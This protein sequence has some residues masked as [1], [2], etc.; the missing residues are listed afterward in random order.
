[1]SGPEGESD[2]MINPYDSIARVPAPPILFD[3]P[4]DEFRG[5]NQSLESSVVARGEILYMP[6]K[7]GEALFLVKQGSVHLLWVTP[8]GR[9]L[10]VGTVRPMICFG[11]MPHLGW[12]MND[13][14]AAAA[15]ESLVC[16]MG[17]ADVER[18]ILSK[19]QIGLRMMSIRNLKDQIQP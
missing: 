17:R 18:L 5:I 14:Y 2:P 16:V 19:P 3:I 4:D 15:E 8:E 9:L 7:T 1:M 6:D 10:I 12:F 11:H 13:L